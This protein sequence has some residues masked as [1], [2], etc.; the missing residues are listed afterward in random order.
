[1]TVQ[2]AILSWSGGKD[3]ALALYEMSKSKDFKITSLLTTL[4]KEFD[5]ISMHG[6]RKDLLTAQAERLHLPLDEVWIG[7]GAQNTEYESQMSRVLSGRSAQGVRHVIF[8]DLFLEDIR[9][10]REDNLSRMNMSGV[11]P[12][13]KKDTKKLASSFIESGFRAVVCAVDP[14]A[15]DP[16]FC[17]R[18]FDDSFLSDLPAQAD[19]CGENGEFHTFVHAG[20]IFD[21]PISVRKGDIILR[22]GFYF[23]DIIPS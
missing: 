15:L 19:P 6:I 20:P 9:R 5:R 11:F 12:L 1:L 16:S 22:D 8:G 10:Y 21:R 13:W 2:R 23:A 17:G 18:D 14:R 4:T 7:K 3:S